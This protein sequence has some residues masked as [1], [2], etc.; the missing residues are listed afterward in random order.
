MDYLRGQAIQHKARAGTSTGT[1]V[2]SRQREV[3]TNRPILTARAIGRLTPCYL[4][5]MLFFF[6]GVSRTTNS[7]WRQSGEHVWAQGRATCV[8]TSVS[9]RGRHVGRLQP[10]RNAAGQ[11]GRRE[12]GHGDGPARRRLRRRGRLWRRRLRRQRRRRRA[13]RRREGQE[14][15]REGRAGGKGRR[16]N[17]NV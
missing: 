9:T 10:E 7:Y 8:C 17:S 3:I 16:E 1:G 13:Q 5:V 14:E 6:D 15:G 4:F 11:L 12:L 2:R